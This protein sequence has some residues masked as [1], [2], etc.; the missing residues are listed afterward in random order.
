MERLA[1]CKNLRVR[2][3]WRENRETEKNDEEADKLEQMIS[4]KEKRRSIPR[5]KVGLTPPT[6]T[7]ASE[8]RT[9]SAPSAAA[10]AAAA[11]AASASGAPIEAPPVVDT[12]KAPTNGIVP[13]GEPPASF[14][15]SLSSSLVYQS[16]APIREVEIK[17]E[18]KGGDSA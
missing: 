6:I 3:P 11:A 17:Q 10:A 8:R 15:S 12:V 14:S 9:Q 1:R 16:A 4:D 13:K 18:V 5:S 2:K 7:R